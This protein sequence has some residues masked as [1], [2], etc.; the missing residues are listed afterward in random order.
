MMVTLTIEQND[1]LSKIYD[2]VYKYIE[3]T[4]E[5]TP[6][7]FVILE[8]KLKQILNTNQY[9]YQQR[10]YLNKDIRKIRERLSKG[11]DAEFLMT[12]VLSDEMGKL[13]QEQIKLEAM[14]W[15]II[16]IPSNRQGK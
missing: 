10:K 2:E 8:T 1:Y 9:H 11:V 14:K 3:V 13:I 16:G 6:H 12:Q 7:E 4:K 15:T 5:H